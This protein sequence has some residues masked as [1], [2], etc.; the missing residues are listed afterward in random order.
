MQWLSKA[1]IAAHFG[2][3]TRTITRWMSERGMP[4]QRPWRGAHPRFRIADCERWHAG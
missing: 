1:E 3:S 4:F 2:V